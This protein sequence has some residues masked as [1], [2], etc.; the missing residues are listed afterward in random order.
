MSQWHYEI[1]DI[2]IYTT[3]E[4]EISMHMLAYIHVKV[5]SEDFKWIVDERGVSQTNLVSSGILTKF[6]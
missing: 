2:I 4:L 6:Y 3:G 1:Y 5:E